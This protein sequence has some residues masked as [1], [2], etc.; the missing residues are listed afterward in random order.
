M[1]GFW[2]DAE[3]ISRYTRA[4]AIDDGVL[5]DVSETARESGFTVPVAL[6]RSVWAL[7]EPTEEETSYGQDFKGR[8]W[9][10]LFMAHMGIK[11]SRGGGTEMVYE[12]IFQMRGRSYYRNGQHTMKLKLHSG[13]GDEGEHVITIMLPE[14]D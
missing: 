6:T 1:T 14:E 13:P 7:V 5:V 8:L 3:V 11:R 12:L 10:V 2:D 4:Q 9:D